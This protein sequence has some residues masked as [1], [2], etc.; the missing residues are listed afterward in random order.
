MTTV[1]PHRRNDDDFDS[2]GKTVL[3]TVDGGQV[4]R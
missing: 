1:G 2:S 3:V 4:L